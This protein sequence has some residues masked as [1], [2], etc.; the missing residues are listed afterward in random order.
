MA[1]NQPPVHFHLQSSV[2]DAPPMRPTVPVDIAAA[3]T[4]E[5]YEKVESQSTKLDYSRRDLNIGPA[6]WLVAMHVVALTAP[7]HSLGPP[8]RW[9]LY[10][11]G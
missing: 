2:L 1:K 10:S 11:I 6:I 8:W 7:G 5:A 4:E 3:D 9:P